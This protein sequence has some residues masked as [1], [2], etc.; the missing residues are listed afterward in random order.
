MSEG[1][2]D[3]DG[4]LSFCRDLWAAADEL[5]SLASK[6]DDLADIA[7]K[8]WEGP[9]KNDFVKA[10][11]SDTEEKEIAET[12]LR[13]AADDWARAWVQAMSAKNKALHQKAVD[14]ADSSWEWLP[15]F[16]DA[17]VTELPEL[18]IVPF[19]P[20]FEPTISLYVNEAS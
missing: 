12:A 1:G 4:T 5:A 17:P 10:V 6:R 20:D 11:D 3:F 2:F 15:G 13:T 18:Y 16:S 9:H 7:T 19:G 14:E 8:H